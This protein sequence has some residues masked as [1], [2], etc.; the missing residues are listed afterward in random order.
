[1]GSSSAGQKILNAVNAQKQLDHLALVSS[2]LLGN[3]VNSSNANGGQ[4]SEPVFGIGRSGRTYSFGEHGAE[5]ITP[6]GQSGG[7]GI[8]INIA[9]IEKNAD[10]EQLKPMIQKWILEAN[11]RRGMI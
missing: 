5:T 3:T 1:M 4:I 9:R 8:T 2:G 10:F 6:N 11:S 7:G